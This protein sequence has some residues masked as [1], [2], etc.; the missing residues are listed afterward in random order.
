MLKAKAENILP[1]PGNLLRFRQVGK[2]FQTVSAVRK[3]AFFSH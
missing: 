2:S 3:W 1:D